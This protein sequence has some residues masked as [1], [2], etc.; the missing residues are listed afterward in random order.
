MWIAISLLSHPHLSQ[1]CLAKCLTPV[2]L[3]LLNLF[4]KLNHQF[5]GFSVR[6]R[7][8]THNYTLGPS[9]S[10]CPT[11]TIHYLTRFY[12]SKT[13]LTGRQNHHIRTTEFQAKNLFSGYNAV[14]FFH[15]SEFERIV[16]TRKSDTGTKQGIFDFDLLSFWLGIIVYD[17]QTSFIRKST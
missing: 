11:Q 7:P 16:G 5:F 8:H 1:H 2:R 3:A 17:L 4:V 14:A 15:V 6:N 9:L 13:C 12:L 10:K